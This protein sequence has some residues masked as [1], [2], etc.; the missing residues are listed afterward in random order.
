M[1]RGAEVGIPTASNAV[2]CGEGNV[3]ITAAMGIPSGNVLELYTQSVGGSP[4]VTDNIP[5][6]ELVTPLIT[7]TTTY[8]VGSLNTATGCRSLRTQ[9]LALVS[10]VPEPPIAN[11][12]ARCGIGSVYFTAGITD[13]YGDAIRVYQTSAGNTL[14]YEDINFPYEF[15]TPSLE[16]TT[17]F[18][19][20][21]V[22]RV[23][24]CESLR[25]P[26][27]VTITSP[28]GIP[29]ALPVA[30]CGAGSLVFTPSIAPNSV[31][32]VRLY[33]DQNE[34]V[35]VSTTPPYLLTTPILYFDAIFS[36]EAVRDGCLSQRGQVLAKVNSIPAPPFV[37][38]VTRCGEGAVT[39][40]ASATYPPG[41]Q[42]ELYS[43]PVGGVPLSTDSSEPYEMVTP[44]L[45]TSTTFYVAHRN[46]F[47]GCVSERTVVVV[48]V[49]SGVVLPQ[50]AP[51][52]RCGAG[53][54]IF[55]ATMSSP[56][57]D[58]IRLY[59]TPSGGQPL[60][61]D[62]YDPFTITTPE[63]SQ[64]T[65]FYLE[66][67]NSQTGCV[68]IGRTPVTAIVNIP[69]GIPNFTS[70]GRC[71]AGIA[72]LTAIMS[73]PGGTEVRFYDAPQAGALLAKDNTSIYE[74]VTP[75]LT[76][77]TTYYAAS[78]DA[79][80]GCE[81][82]RAP[83][84]VTI[85]PVPGTPTVSNASRCGAGKVV[86][87]AMMGVPSGTDIRLYSSNIVGAAAVDIDTESPFELSTPTISSS[88]IYFV[89]SY[90]A[91][92]GCESARIPVT[93]VI[94]PF[95]SLP[96]A[97]NVKRCGPGIATIVAT[98]PS[99][100]GNQVRLFE[101]QQGGVP[102]VIDPEPP[103]LLPTPVISTNTTYYIEG[104]NASRGCPST[105]RLPV[106]V[107]IQELPA[108]AIV[109]EVVRCRPGILT[110]TVRIGNPPGNKVKLYDNL[111]A[112]NPIAVAFAPPY[113]LT[114]G[115]VIAS[116]TF[117]IE[118]ENTQ[119]GCNSERVPVGAKIV[120]AP[121]M[122]FAQDVERCGPGVVTFTAD[123]GFLPGNQILM[124]S[125]PVGGLPLQA[126]ASPPYTFQTEVL[127]ATRT[128]YL[129]SY[130][131]ATG[132]ESERRLVT[133]TI[134]QRPGP[135][136][137][138]EVARC[139]AGSI[140]FT[141]TMGSPAGSKIAVYDSPQ[142]NVPISVVTAAP[143][144]IETPF[145]ATTTTFYL[146][147]IIGS[148]GCVS[149]RS[150][151]VARVNIVPAA[152]S[153]ESV[154][155]CGGGQVTFSLVLPSPAGNVVRAY[156]LPSSGA[157]IA[158]D[159]QPPYE[160]SL[161]V[162]V[163]STFYFSSVISTTNCESMRSAAIAEVFPKPGIPA[164]LD[165]SR[166]GPGSVTFTATMTSPPGS[167]IRIYNAP[168]S[169]LLLGIDNTS[170]YLLNTPE[171]NQ[172]TTYY[173][174]SFNTATNCESDRVAAVLT[175]QPIPAEPTVINM[176]RCG[177][178]PVT[179]TTTMNQ[180][181]GNEMRLFEA[182]SGG[183]AIARDKVAPYLLSVPY[184]AATRSYFVQAVD[185]STGCES[186]RVPVDIEIRTLPFAPKVSDVSICGPG[187]AT[188]TVDLLA[189][190]T[191]GLR[192]LLYTVPVGGAPIFTDILPPYELVATN[193]FATT[194]F[195]V[196]FYNANILCSSPRVPVIANV[197][198]NPS[199]PTVSSV[200]RCGRGSVTI[201]AF[202]GSV[203]GQ[204]IRFYNVPSGGEPLFG[205]DTS[206]YRYVTP[207]LENTTVFYVEAVG[208]G[209]CKSQRTA[210]SA[211]IHPLPAKPAVSSVQRCG[212]GVVTFTP[213]MGIPAGNMTRLYDQAD[214]IVA[215]S[216]IAPT[217]ALTTPNQTTTTI[218]YI[219]SYNSITGCASERVPVS[220]I[221]VPLPGSPKSM[222]IERCGASIVTFTAEMG[223]PPGER[224]AIYTSPTATTP[225]SV[226][227]HPPY[228][229]TTP[230]NTT[231]TAYY[232][233][234]ISQVLG[235][236][237]IRTV[238]N[239]TILPVPVPSVSSNTPVCLGSVVNLSAS[240]PPGTTFFWQGPNGFTAEGS[241]P[242]FVATSSAVAGLYTLT[243]KLG[244][245]TSTPITQDISITLTPI[246]PIATYYNVLQEEQPLCEGQELN[247]RVINIRDYP[248]GATFIWSGP[249]GYYLSSE[250]AF[251]AIPNMT[252]DREGLY[253]VA[254]VVNGCTSATS[255]GVEVKVF[256][257]PPPPVATN[258]SPLCANTGLI[259]LYASEV[260]GDI[261][262]VWE[263]PN[264]FTA[265][266]RTAARLPIP[267]NAGTYYVQAIDKNG[268]RSGLD[269][270]VVVIKQNP[271]QPVVQV[272][273][274]ICVGSELR[275][276][277]AG[278]LGTEFRVRGPNNYSAVG[279]GPEFTRSNITF[280]DAGVYS[281]VAVIDGCS[282]AI[283][284][285]EV[286][287][288]A[289]PAMPS[290]SSNGPVCQGRTLLLT[291]ISQGATLYKWTGPAGYDV[292][293]N[294]P[295]VARLNAQ[296]NFS[297]NYSVTAIANGCTSMPA[298]LAVVVNF[299]P[300]SPVVSNPIPLCPGEILSMTASGAGNVNYHWMGP[301]G[302]AATGSNI[303]RIIQSSLQGG[304]YSVAAFQSNCTSA[305]VTR[306]VVVKPKPET[307]TVSNS[308][309]VCIGREVLFTATSSQVASFNWV[310]PAAFVASGANVIR[311]ITSTLEAGIY[312]VTA[313]VD[314]CVSDPATTDLTIL[315]SPPVP[316]VSSNA[317]LCIG[318]TLRLSASGGPLNAVYVWSGPNGFSASTNMPTI[319]RPAL[320]INDAGAYSVYIQ[321]PGCNSDPGSAFVSIIPKPSRP[322]AQSDAPKCV[323][324]MV[325]F[326]A[327]GPTA[328]TYR[329]RGPNNFNETGQVVSRFLTST[330]QAGTYSVVAVSGS[331]ESDPGEV[332]IV[333]RPKPPAPFAENDG[334][335]CAGQNIRLT[336]T[337]IAGASYIWQGPNGFS[338]T[339]ATVSRT[340]STLLDAGSY[341]VS[342]V[343]GGCTSTVTTTEVRVKPVP[344][345]IE[346]S[347]NSPLCVGDLLQ[348]TATAIQ[349]ATYGWQ[350]PDAFLA[351]VPQP[352]RSNVTTAQ[353]GI[354]WVVVS[355]DGCTSRPATVE[356]VINER[357]LNPTV[358]S[359]SPLCAGSTLELSAN[360]PSAAATYL[361]DGP[362]GFVSREKSPERLNVNTPDEGVYNVVAIIGNCTSDISSTYVIVRRR[363][364]PPMITNNSTLCE[365]QNL[366]LNASL[367]PGAT[368][369]WTGPANFISN[370]LNPVRPN[371]N[372]T[373]AGIYNAVAIQNGCTSATASTTVVINPTPPPA[374]ISSNSP[375]CAGSTLS[376]TASIVPG[377]SYRWNGPEGFSSTLQTPSINNVALN[378]GGVYTLITLIGNCASTPAT[379]EVVV[380]P[381]P[382]N[383]TAGN[384]GPLC[385]G[386]DLV[387][388]AT[389]VPGAT[390]LWN[391][392][393][394][395]TSSQQNPL[396]P[397]VTVRESGSYSLT[398]RIGDCIAQ[399]TTT[400]II[401]NAI[402]Q[403]PAINSNAPICAGQNLQLSTSAVVGATYSWVG[404]NGFT[405]LLQNPVIPSAT[406]A[407]SGTYSLTVRVGACVSP[408]ASA[409][410][411]VRPTPTSVGIETNGST[412]CAGSPLR[413]NASFIL[414]ARYHWSGPNGFISSEQSPVIANPAVANSGTYS[415]IVTLGECSSAQVTTNITVNPKPSGIAAFNSGPVC[416]GR[417]L[418]L[419]ASFLSGAS[420]Q[421]SGPNG[422][423][424]GFQ[425]VTI[426]NVQIA[427]AGIYTLI[428]RVGGCNSDPITTIV[429]VIPTPE[430][431]N[432]LSNSPLCSGETLRLTATPVSG[433][434]YFWSGPLGL[435]AT[436]RVATFT[437]V[438][439]PYSGNYSV[440]AIVGGCTS[441][442]G[443]VPVIVN[444]NPQPPIIRA[445]S[446][447]CSGQTLQLSTELQPGAEYEWRGP[448]NFL[449][450][451]VAP[452]RQSVTTADRGIYSLIVSIGRCV[453][454]PALTLIEVI[455]TPPAPIV[456]SN[457]P[458]CAGG[459]LQLSINPL[460]GVTYSW[461]GPAGFSSALVSP[462]L[463]NVGT[464][465]AGMYSVVASLGNCSSATV[466]HKVEVV[467]I[468]NIDAN[469][470]GP[471]CT[472]QTLNL[473][474]T[475]VEG[476]T[477]QWFGPNNFRS[478]AQNPSIV[479]VG[480]QAAGLYSVIAILGNCTSNTAV[481]NVGITAI[482]DRPNIYN[483]SPLC[484]GETL[485]L[486]TDFI[487]GASYSWSGPRN[488]SSNGS[489]VTRSNLRTHDAGVYSLLVQVGACT[490]NLATTI[491]E[492][493]PAP[494]NLIARSNAP[495]CAGSTLLLSANFIN[496]ANYNWRGP[497]N[498]SASG[499][500]P[501][502]PNISTAQAG[503]Y[504][505]TATLGNCTARSVVNVEVGATPEVL[506]VRSS[507]PV[508][509][510]GV[511]EL[512]APLIPG[513]N[514]SWV[515]PNG[516]S[517]AVAN[518]V[519]S[520]ISLADAGEY[521]LTVFAAGCSSRAAKTLVEVFTQPERPV[522]RNNGPLCAGQNLEL[523]ATSI[524]GA[525][526]LWSGPGGFS[527]TAQNPI[528]LGVNASMA[529]R[530]TVVA[531]LNECVSL[532][533]TTEVVISEP[534]ASIRAI[535]PVICAG[536]SSGIEIDLQ[537]IAPWRLQYRENGILGEF[538][539]TQTPYRVS[540]LPP[541]NISYTLVSLI[542][543][544]NC[545]VELKSSAEIEVVAEPIA[546]LLNA[547][548]ICPGDSSKFSI[549]I[550]G[551]REQDE[552]S[553]VYGIENREFNARG[554]GS[555][556]IHLFTPP[557]YSNTTIRLRTLDNLTV[558]CRR[559]LNSSIPV[560]VIP[561]AT[562]RFISEDMTICE[563]VEI[564]WGFELTGKGPWQVAYAVNGAPDT[565]VLGTA[566]TP[567][568]ARF[569]FSYFPRQTV[570]YEI[571]NVRGADGC[572]AGAQDTF[573]IFVNRL[574]RPA[575]GVRS[576]S[577]VCTGDT[578]RLYA[579]G[580]VGADFFWKGPNGYTSLTA[581]PII[582]PVKKE[583][584]GVYTVVT[585]ARG[586]TTNVP[587][588][589]RVQV[590]Q[591]PSVSVIARPA[592][593]CIGQAAELI[594]N[595]NGGPA[596]SFAW[597]EGEAGARIVNGVESMHYRLTVVP[598][599]AGDKRYII[600]QLIDSAGCVGLSAQT[601]LRVLP[602]PFVEVLEVT[603]PG[604]GRPTG[605][606]K[607]RGRGGV[608]SLYRYG[609]SGRESMNTSGE[610]D[611]LRGGVYTV[612]V[613]SGG[614][615][616]TAQ[617][618][619][620]SAAQ[621]EITAIT[622]TEEQA[623]NSV[624]LTWQSTAGAASYTLLY[625][626]SGEAN[627]REVSGIRSTSYTLQG[628][629]PNTR[630]EFSIRTLCANGQV[631]GNSAIQTYTTASPSAGCLTPG[632]ITVQNITRSSARV[633][634]RA[635][636][637]AV[638]Y[639]ITYGPVG[640]PAS[641]W[642]QLL[643]PANATSTQLDNLQA[644]VR[645]GVVMQTNCS[646]CSSRA[647]TRS[648]ESNIIEFLTLPSREAQQVGSE[649]ILVNAKLY[650]NPTQGKVI[651][652]VS[653]FS[654]SELEIRI[655]DLEGRV[656]QKQYILGKM[657]DVLQVE[658]D[659]SN[660]SSGIYILQLQSKG[661]I[662]TQ[663]IIVQK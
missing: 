431:P 105:N 306:I 136:L 417:N 571:L 276:T 124:Y 281:F 640:T 645:Y 508:C 498:Y 121:D 613:F 330:L 251:P 637:G 11:N 31:D 506:E 402:T 525:R 97:E 194:T 618:V 110:F 309:P 263:G 261:R 272:S 24:G 647:G 435:N 229:F 450:R 185:T 59:D 143:Y 321:V 628:L 190:S 302:F 44:H 177:P 453:S 1:T 616:A 455:P 569:T 100:P 117:F 130:S 37:G 486:S 594:L 538:F 521:T 285:V 156:T 173:F 485:Q 441:A 566:A 64:T 568:P 9:V 408:V 470:N 57:G 74:F 548:T 203:P 135:P 413:F 138:A 430:A 364:N 14:L 168:T 25:I 376:L 144:E 531:L 43:T 652:E 137:A 275:F 327:V 294:T 159:L 201:N 544:L 253:Y 365:G 78:F 53:R 468:R 415:L 346:A 318:Q 503:L 517:S 235:C 420:Y 657:D 478:L 341:S 258:N 464:A 359:N 363:P 656:L 116:T 62:A 475:F 567:S 407:N 366:Q 101:V 2:R 558:G 643:V 403:P 27:L 109:E 397:K 150:P 574:P 549:L 40:T 393:N 479:N 98:M 128:F 529:G 65:T 325:T 267:A 469:S 515:G 563:G 301:G 633:T 456:R 559:L 158:L 495:I 619:M 243:A 6:F 443:V 480:I 90:N 660:Y 586:C 38:N 86:F 489:I 615:S 381:A 131:S 372:R 96:V 550:Q 507:S 23:S 446:Q 67:L 593:I 181:M 8:Y 240:A 622:S 520:N 242:S 349:G 353:A 603:E 188:F 315:P 458:V 418:L 132:C 582:I 66:S 539:V 419:T 423:S 287:P 33:N 428:A 612:T 526:Y 533:T 305:P 239:V 81:S 442:P 651:L 41:T 178:G 219:D 439:P 186:K 581:N 513:A 387:L 629:S 570:T 111:L 642:S 262:Y 326:N 541:G 313:T 368:I 298:T 245:C 266:T 80:T 339:G 461:R 260:P 84:V 304:I 362:G 421:W 542:D 356:V 536:D 34:L 120:V 141:A 351:G 378:Q 16:T 335:K 382:L 377:A 277:V 634:W 610:F 524:P 134:Y 661:I 103:F 644:G 19:L 85:H 228:E 311:P 157:P 22:N 481:V 579:S 184:V 139:G 483:N 213:A 588:E 250:L 333:V 492:I 206:P 599:T 200:S 61:T 460:A 580:E 547:T 172:T 416:S 611:E 509:V 617:V 151:I 106:V 7:T 448:N 303:T 627:W 15:T 71:G 449:A 530:Y 73:A 295:Q 147:S 662:K 215:T 289:T 623:H 45:L 596:F 646:L 205:D 278:L 164:V 438:S 650:P 375:V 75:I 551:L 555:G 578:L 367:V 557:L 639:I 457:T 606:I 104:Y 490:A 474:A 107:T 149:D 589:T 152:P 68:S 476:A 337:G 389:F 432:V 274:P 56:A 654:I 451:E 300:A 357:P 273:N 217:Y 154:K 472:G 259:Q 583:N 406:T 388:S 336:A 60:A 370:E 493:N 626:V 216:T 70:I 380:E 93:A 165:V 13:F 257:R 369:R 482:P 638:C 279:L 51:V 501:V 175:V 3:I 522:V 585:I 511:L 82:F 133:A 394:G 99:A 343:A 659:L 221:I 115:T 39:F 189:G 658:L 554:K 87:S 187:S 191:A 577:P 546:Q 436:D 505:V 182:F 179:F 72:T 655:L 47:T 373:F 222:D 280:A 391:G 89:A 452:I 620:P 328:L 317:P 584:E 208:A 247:L 167:Q 355:L 332:N 55:S 338:S 54:V 473:S 102:I 426:S 562:A 437:N 447:I 516:F 174:S 545:A 392:P 127:Q 535:K 463:F 256:K 310:G 223:N 225:L 241:N 494:L 543:G 48:T 77:T 32:E 246:T 92:T 560:K 342:V 565:L 427:A 411:L 323:G 26:L 519:R 345:P 636:S 211:V 244:N 624:T 422:F 390:Y 292:L 334:P 649:L 404:P 161:N 226:D 282:S 592:E 434:R 270:T 21:S 561:P 218:Y 12:V 590:R 30:R 466:S 598:Q 293:V 35:M 371:V 195:Y 467:P 409:E 231:S 271:Q 249:A 234:A 171:V 532:P 398:V 254:V 76:T 465:N 540:L 210:V 284:R 308:G 36:I 204:E 46:Q 290:V 604:C 553:L 125:L 491:V 193:L 314:G 324:E 412:I 433:A 444:P 504:T 166:C 113:T 236:R 316:F 227:N 462:T 552:W 269:S 148:T 126:D 360:S 28:P 230:L 487:P 556:V 29:T 497:A 632:N 429:E 252:T 361:W 91:Q 471:L 608:D 108:P 198:P 183:N 307:P 534:R 395:F 602:N 597:Q 348:L 145:I 424:A 94:H 625:R 630:Y 587:I 112:I 162:Q 169:G 255:Q 170:P 502:V 621:A 496:G 232:L 233:E 52:A 18:Y 209:G 410:I 319:E 573:T 237:S 400:V 329:W 202:M 42:L 5:P 528:R 212:A 386:Q 153:V 88:T 146:E 142:G 595:F 477:Y 609:I 440:V 10:K 354:Y 163:T 286:A 123:M 220:A 196:E 523:F 248:P 600:S 20:S 648:T 63:I 614:C 312:S 663:K 383:I 352:T 512:Y 379:T 405:S 564:N 214:L 576:N 641:T 510:G 283:S 224:I 653:N 459:N 160:I 118:V 591:R 207:S 374:I 49:Y 454:D 129:A 299:T 79:A 199:Q 607:V 514:Y 58:V 500:A 331:C 396:L 291:A 95:A 296:P 264:N 4:I 401:Q 297:G 119:T 180:P 192:A 527:S 155:T 399:A 635:V 344:P 350:G 484:E 445:P 320:G 238:V 384:N 17:T 140:T 537:G 322:G 265:T 197:L 288:R 518:P 572:F 176:A 385:A 50:A 425:N 601:T 69:P 605:R 347:S 358:T 488:F 83:A 114:T 414:G 122:P 499:P 631:A 340:L 268:C 575:S